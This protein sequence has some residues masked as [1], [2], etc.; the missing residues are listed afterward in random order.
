LLFRLSVVAANFTRYAGGKSDSLVRR[1]RR[2]LSV[3]EIPTRQ[4]S[5]QPVATGAV[6][7]ITKRP[8][9]LV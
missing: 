8:K 1:E 3:G 5:L 6:V 4:L 7:E 2:V 9:P